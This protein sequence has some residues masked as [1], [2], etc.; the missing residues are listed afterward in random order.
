MVLLDL[1]LSL[2]RPETAHSSKAL[3]CEKR[4]AIPPKPAT[5]KK[6]QSKTHSQVA[7]GKVV[8]TIQ[9]SQHQVICLLLIIYSRSSRLLGT[10][11][12]RLQFNEP[13]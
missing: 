6:L 5:T 8:T 13:L 2:T 4:H 3:Q 9:Q 11:P 12:N 7:K 1:Y 10:E